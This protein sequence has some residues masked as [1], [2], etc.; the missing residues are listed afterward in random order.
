[1][2]RSLAL[3][4][5]ALVAG[6]PAW[7]GEVLVDFLDVGQ[8]DAVLIRGGGKAVLID[9]GI[10]RARVADQ[11]AA[12]DVARLDLVITTHPHADHMGGMEDVVR[13]YP[14]GLYVDN[15]LPHTTQTYESLMTAIEELDIPYRAGRT[16]LQLN[17]GTEATLR[18]LLP[19]DTAL[20]GTRSDLNSNSVVTLLS[21][22]EVDVLLTGDAEEPTEALLARQD[23]PSIEVL[24]VAHHGSAHSSTAGFLAT[25]RPTYAV[26]SC[27]TDNRYG[28]PDPEAMDR[29]H[30]SGAMVFRT[31]LSGHIRAVSDGRAVELLELGNLTGVAPSAPVAGRQPVGGTPAIL[32]RGPAAPPPPR[33]AA[34]DDA[35]DGGMDAPATTPAAPPPEPTNPPAASRTLDLSGLRPAPAEDEDPPR[36][37]KKKKKQ[38][39]REEAP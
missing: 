20:S 24:K 32:G 25:V 34:M 28:H 13:R 1:M 17:L 7:A 29:L 35:M 39:D 19:G 21:H 2:A 10:K 6:A 38:R 15:G 9:A 27:G 36:R 26:I 22:G 11:L 18:V 3:V 33:P 23:L 12:L 4:L 30:G 37:R 16:G 31:D 14:I 5:L 8:G